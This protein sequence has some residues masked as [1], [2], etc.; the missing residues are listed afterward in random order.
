MVCFIGLAFGTL[1]GDALLH[2]IPSSLGIHSHEDSSDSHSHQK[3]IQGLEVPN[4]IW[5]QLCL[6]ASIYAL[7]LFEVIINAIYSDE[8]V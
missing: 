2:L 6:L 5:Y 8:E 1:S 7:F 3:Q 4:Y